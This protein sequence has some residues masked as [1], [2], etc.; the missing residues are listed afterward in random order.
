MWKSVNNQYF[1]LLSNVV[2]IFYMNENKYLSLLIK[3]K[4]V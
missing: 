1:F 3:E 2:N 4:I